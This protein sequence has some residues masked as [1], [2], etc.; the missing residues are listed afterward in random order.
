MSNGTI[1]RNYT[2]LIMY[3]SRC[4]IIKAKLITT[5]SIHPSV[6]FC[7]EKRCKDIQNKLSEKEKGEGLGKNIV[8]YEENIIE[9]I[10]KKVGKKMKSILECDNHKSKFLN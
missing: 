2:L 5:F 6:N 9:W 10:R 8:V 3:W 4:S 1:Q 7:L